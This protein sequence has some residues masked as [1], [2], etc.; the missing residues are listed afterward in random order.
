MVNLLLGNKWSGKIR[1]EN[2]L[3][4]E[5]IRG[6]R[7]RGWGKPTAPSKAFFYFIYATY[8]SLY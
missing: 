2:Y 7:Q 5:V 6:K 4:G 3:L 1:G 8:L